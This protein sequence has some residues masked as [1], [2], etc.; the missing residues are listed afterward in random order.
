[1]LLWQKS[2]S[3]PICRVGIAGDFLPAGG[4]TLPKNRTWSD[5]AE[6]IA[7]NFRD[8]DISIVNLECPL[9]VD[10]LPPRLKMRLGGTFSAPEGAWAPPA[11]IEV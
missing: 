1:M 10:G 9:A 5:L 11:G 2:E 3:E 6:E 8:L 4:L 7:E